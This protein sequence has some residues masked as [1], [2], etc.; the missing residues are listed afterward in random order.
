[1]YTLLLQENEKQLYC[2]GVE[3]LLFASNFILSNFF[4][5]M[6]EVNL[7]NQIVICRIMFFIFQKINVCFST[8]SLAYIYVNDLK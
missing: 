8:W 6:G 3:G 2:S 1:M 5:M 4:R 7:Q